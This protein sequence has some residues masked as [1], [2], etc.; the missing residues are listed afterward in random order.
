MFS[1]EQIKYL[2]RGPS[3]CKFASLLH[4]L[5]LYYIFFMLMR[6]NNVANEISESARQAM[7]RIFAEKLWQDQF[8]FT[9]YC[10]EMTRE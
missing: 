8:Q 9:A 4:S 2:P 7:R 1:E 6:N 5:P 10:R 3:E